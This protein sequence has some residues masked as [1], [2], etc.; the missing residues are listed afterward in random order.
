MHEFWVEKLG[1]HGFNIEKRAEVSEFS[2]V[3]EGSV[4]VEFSE[5]TNKV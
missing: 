2:E 4:R 1:L 5:A 3:R